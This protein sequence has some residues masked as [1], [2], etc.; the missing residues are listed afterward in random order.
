M[1]AEIL[2]LRFVHVLSGTLWVG[3]AVFSSAFLFPA[4]QEAGPAAGAVMAGMQKRKVM[5]YFPILAIL[6]VLSG[7]R[8]IWIDSG[9]FNPSYFRTSMG[10]GLATGAAF[11]LTAFVL[12]FVVG[13]PAMARAGAIAE[14]MQTAPEAERPAMGKELQALRARGAAS[15]ALVAGLLV[16]ATI[17]MGVARY[18]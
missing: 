11:A 15:M 14:R 10:M 12:G 4:M 16:L 5:V 2:A 9:G 8:L 1:A 7:L 13:R 18:L 3:S 6:T 17:A